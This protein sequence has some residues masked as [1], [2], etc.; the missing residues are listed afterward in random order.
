MTDLDT[1]AREATR[2]LLDR[3]VPDIASRYAEL[4]RIRARRT[5]AK[6]VAGA[7][8]VVLAV[9]GWQ[10][11]ADRDQQVRPAPATTTT[12]PPYGA[13]LGLHDVASA[14]SAGWR[15]VFGRAPA[16]LPDDADVGVMIQASADGTHLYY[17]DDHH[18]LAAW[19]LATGAKRVLVPCPQTSCFGGS[20]SPAGTTAAFPGDGEVLLTDLQS[21]KSDRIEVPGLHGSPPA[22]SPDGR[23]LAFNN[24]QGLHTVAVEGSDLRLVR[25][26]TDEAT[27]PAYSV[28]WSPDGSR[29]AFFDTVTLKHGSSGL[30]AYNAMTVRSDGTDPVHLSSAGVCPCGRLLPPVLAWSPDGSLVAVATTSAERPS[31]VYTVHPDG[32][33]WTLRAEG[34]WSQ[35]TWQPLTG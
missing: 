10:V 21:G 15:T 29:L 3:S 33:S 8:T 9:G 19:D 32:S 30:T 11:A 14:A 13:L 23:T 27:Y 16:S 6:L 26:A 34:S 2:E 12:T 28:A 31:G 35:L 22:W 20:V 5:T 1:V 4:A 18:R 25:P 17:S 24:A 7:V